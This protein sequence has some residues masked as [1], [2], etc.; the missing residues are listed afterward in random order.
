MDLSSLKTQTQVVHAGYEPESDISQPI[1]LST[2]FKRSSHET[3]GGYTRTGN[4]NRTTLEKKIALLEHGTDAVAFS[5]G[6]AAVN[7]LFEA[8]LKSGD[9]VIYPDD[10]YH[11]T[12]AILKNLLETKGIQSRQVDMSS[13][14]NI[15]SA[16][17]GNTRLIWMETP[18]NPQLKITDIKAV[19]DL[20]KANNIAT[21][22]DSTFA[23]PLFQLP[24]DLG[25]DVVMHSTTKFFS[26][27]SD[28]LGGVLV[29]REQSDLLNR[30]RMYQGIAGAVPSP[31]D[32]WL[33][34]R[35]IATF[36]LRVSMQSSNAMAVA[37]FLAGHKK[38]E[39]VFYPGL[40]SHPNH[41]VAKKQMKGGFGGVLSICVK[42]GQK[43]AI[44]LCR[45]LQLVKH[46]T[47]L[48]GVETL[49]EHRRSA[50][51]AMAV[52]PDNLLRISVGI[53]HIDDL[54]K[55]FGQALE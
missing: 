31:F 39:K 23:T 37:N 16:V 8:T 21:G 44:D 19:A 14:T 20:A 42:G 35:S 46:A 38:I 9:N 51:G 45:K 48:G 25:V 12:R 6:L 40:P 10:C 43:E 17:D 1:H 34:N 26:G 30:I 5:S 29:A 27:H 2:T 50:E 49:I 47:S 28:V 13:V 11:G 33:L 22:C 52:S 36:T 53:E 41:E 18:S 54:L 15:M 7:A 55:D 24:L 3:V 32:C 4:P